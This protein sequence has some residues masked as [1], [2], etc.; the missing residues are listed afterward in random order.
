MTRSLVATAL[1]HETAGLSEAQRLHP[2]LTIL[3]RLVP[4][5]SQGQGFTSCRKKGRA[6]EAAAVL[7][8][9]LEGGEGERRADSPDTP[10]EAGGRRKTDRRRD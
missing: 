9:P 4:A 8:F 10:T 6:V 7:G 1:Q 2:S 3:G 5:P